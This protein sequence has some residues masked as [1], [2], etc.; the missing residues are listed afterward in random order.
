[1]LWKI[2]TS[3]IKNALPIT[4]DAAVAAMFHGAFLT[5]SEQNAPA[6]RAITASSATMKGR[7]AAA[8]MGEENALVSKKPVIGE[9]IAAATPHFEPST[10][11]PIITGRYMGSHLTPP[12]A[13]VAICT[14]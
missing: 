1:M 14:S 3:S 9:R 13:P 12:A 4:S 5:I 7:R 2:T 10:H 6:M 8:G 11:A